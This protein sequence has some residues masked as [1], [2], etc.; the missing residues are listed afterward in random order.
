MTP[1]EFQEIKSKVEKAKENKARAEGA[2]NKIMDNLKKDYK[3]ETIEDAETKLDEL[4]EVIETDK[5][6]LNGYYS[7]LEK[8]ADWDSI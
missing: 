4:N 1:K 7:K 8:V 2:L 5:D 6:K 3:I